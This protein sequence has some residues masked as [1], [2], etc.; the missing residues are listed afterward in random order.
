MDKRLSSMRFRADV[1]GLRGLAILLV[2]AYHAR[3][4]GVSGGFIGVDVFFVLSGY[5][6]TRLL[7]HELETTG[8]IRLA[9]F[10]ARRA[11]RLLPAAAFVLLTTMI[12]ARLLLS[13]VEQQ[14]IASSGLAT[15]LY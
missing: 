7:T 14:I 3:L 2:V 8:R 9:H 1:E 4:P 6:I 12:A 15:A 5:L 10:W 13:P 11:R